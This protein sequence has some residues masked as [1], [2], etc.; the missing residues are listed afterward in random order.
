MAPAGESLPVGRAARIRVPANSANLGPGFDSLGVAF[1]WYD[2]CELE[3][4]AEGVDVR[5]TGEGADSVPTDRSHLVLACLDRGLAALGAYAPGVRLVA[6]NTIPHTRGLG[7]SAAAAVAGLLGAWTLARPGEPVDTDWLLGEAYAVEGHADNVAAAILGGFV[8]TW[9]DDETEPG[10]VHAVRAEVHPAVRLLAYVHAD[11]VATPQ[12][13]GV[14]PEAVPHAEA[15]AN[16]ARAALLTHALGRAPELLLPATRE[17][18]HQDQ[19]T[20][21]M[22]DSLELLKSLRAKG[23]G[24]VISGAG[25]TVLVL[26]DADRAD[27]L[28]GSE[29]PGFTLHRLGLG[30][31]A[32]S[33]T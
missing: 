21:L 11:P 27:R 18:L 8:L 9:V 30:G 31:G 12:A 1:D 4:L 17:W 6:H 10:R 28:D 15:A 24:A 13:R 23:F 5:V 25:P 2:E 26:T 22:P 20:A 3:V 32:T 29:A 19:R 33:D 16:A 7:S 14:L